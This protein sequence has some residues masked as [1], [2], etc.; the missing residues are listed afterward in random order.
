[1]GAHAGGRSIAAGRLSVGRANG[2]RSQ[3]LGELT[4]EW[5]AAERMR[6]G[7]YVPIEGV[8]GH[9]QEALER[10]VLYSVAQ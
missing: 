9:F 10:L 4:R 8:Q 1:M 6:D 7:L 3:A 5:F 2:R